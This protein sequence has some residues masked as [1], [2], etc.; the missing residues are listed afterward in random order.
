MLIAFYKVGT[1]AVG[2]EMPPLAVAAG[3]SIVG[4]IIVQETGR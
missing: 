3:T 2:L 1:L 4:S